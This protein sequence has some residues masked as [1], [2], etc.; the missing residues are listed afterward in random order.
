[1]DISIETIS[2]GSFIGAIIVVSVNIWLNQK[3]R[4]Y[5]L[6]KERLTHFYNPI[7]AFLR[8]KWKP[9]KD[10]E[11]KTEYYDFFMELQT[12]FLENEI[13]ASKELDK[14]FNNMQSIHTGEYN[15][16]YL[17]ENKSKYKDMREFLTNS[18]ESNLQSKIFKLKEPIEKF[19]EIFNKDFKKLRNKNF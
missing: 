12:K 10:S 1:M 7:N 3:N 19:I 11:L 14:V 9:L 16:Y 17:E 6:V 15:K 4:Q 2:I 13:Y 5:D 8:T 18:P